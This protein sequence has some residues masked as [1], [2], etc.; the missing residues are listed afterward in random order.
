MEDGACGDA[1]EHCIPWDEHCIP[2]EMLPEN[3]IVWDHEMGFAF[4]HW[5]RG[6]PLKIII[7]IRR[8]GKYKE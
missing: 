6:L 8:I 5:K 2:W 7:K 1:A 3:R 4:P